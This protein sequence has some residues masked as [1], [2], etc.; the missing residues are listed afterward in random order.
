MKQ[1]EINELA[2][3]LPKM[4]QHA[5]DAISWGNGRRSAAI[6]DELTAL[7]EAVQGAANLDQLVAAF[8][9]A[10]REGAEQVLMTE[11]E[12][13]AELQN[14][15]DNGDQL[16]EVDDGSQG[17]RDGIMVNLIDGTLTAYAS[18]PGLFEGENDF[19]EATW[20]IEIEAGVS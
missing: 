2:E 5:R 20:P 9:K 18:T 1:T 10:A 7:N 12:A 19:V 13:R 4:I 6:I 14:R 8:Y 3:T 11:A 15:L 16:A 17:Q